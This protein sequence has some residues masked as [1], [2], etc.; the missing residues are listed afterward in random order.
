MGNINNY[1][2]DYAEYGA[3]YTPSSAKP[4]DN[5]NNQTGH[6]CSAFGCPLVGS[7]SNS[8]KGDGKWFCFM[9]IRAMPSDWSKIT[10]KLK[11]NS[12]LINKML[13]YYLNHDYDNYHASRKELES[14]C[15]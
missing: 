9:H 14:V 11:N 4:K 15:R 2:S 12:Q 7:M 1:Y 8:T 13:D 10:H 5:D 6:G 3:I